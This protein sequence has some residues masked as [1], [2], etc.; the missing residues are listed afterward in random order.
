MK[1]RKRARVSVCVRESSRVHKTNAFFC[2]RWEERRI[3][4]RT[5]GRT[6]SRTKW[7]SEQYTYACIS[8]MSGRK[9]IK[10]VRASA[11]LVCVCEC[12]RLCILKCV[13]E[14]NPKQ[15]VRMKSTELFQKPIHYTMY[16][17]HCTRSLCSFTIQKSILFLAVAVCHRW[18]ELLLLLLDYTNAVE[19]TTIL[20][21]AQAGKNTRT[22]KH[23][24]GKRHTIHTR[25]HIN[26]FYS[27][28]LT[29]K[30]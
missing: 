21:C 11:F 18:N 1:E 23:T 26:I 15:C 16:I 27:S 4:E 28:F 9:S 8:R 24:N 22:H 29:G 7:A 3:N 6:N 5:D 17:V 25:A 14:S 13:L 20:V 2:F 30:R 19:R 10:C 12:E